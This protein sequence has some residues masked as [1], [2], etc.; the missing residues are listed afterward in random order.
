MQ[1]KKNERWITQIFKSLWKLE[2]FRSDRQQKNQNLLRLL[3]IF[4]FGL[5][6]NRQNCTRFVL[7][8]QNSSRS[9][10]YKPI[11]PKWINVKPICFSKKNLN[12]K[13]K[14]HKLWTTN[15]LPYV[16]SAKHRVK[17]NYKSNHFF[18]IINKINASFC[19]SPRFIS[20]PRIMFP[21]P[22]II[23]LVIIFLTAI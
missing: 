7:S 14:N 5:W 16:T 3:F 6:M 4:P 20:L 23:F 10:I 2:W 22:N 17:W 18:R 11:S 9:F 1:K 19:W 12:I 8:C 15:D 13:H 21:T